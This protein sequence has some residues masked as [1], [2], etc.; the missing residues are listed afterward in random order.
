MG[1][2]TVLA[3][4]AGVTALAAG[5]GAVAQKSAADKAAAAQKKAL[6]EQNSAFGQ[7]NPD[8]VNK[9]AQEADAERAKGRVAL[10][11]ELDPELA[12]LRQL[13]KEG[14]VAVAA[15]D[16]I[17]KASDLLF[18]EN[19]VAD[20]RLEALKDQLINRAQEELNL[21][22]SLPAEFQNELVRA[23]VSRGAATG[24]AIDQRSIG[25][26][27]AQA[28]G[29]AGLALQRNR[30]QA[31][32]NLIGQAQAITD[33]RTNILANIFPKVETVRAATAAGQFATAEQALPEFGLSGE[34][35]ANLQIA[36]VQAQNA[37]TQ[38]K[39]DLS[40]QNAM[41]Q[42]QFT[43]Q[44]IGAGAGALTGA[45]GAASAGGAF[46][47]VPTSPGVANPYLGAAAGSV[48]YSYSGDPGSLVNQR[49][50][51]GV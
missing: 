44:L 10:Q 16:R 5:A 40:A 35:I 26:P 3:I 43:S 20:P 36:R 9:L 50:L 34:N 4:T 32:G 13:G 18:K 2:A 51:Y 11:K 8:R 46:S 17:R 33:A 22:A 39:A 42:G 7:L 23:G 1:V 6:K 19:A 15:D 27:V 49:F 30:E 24:L 41:A 29:S 21:G 12:Q 31:A 48:P 47:S 25:G 45:L 28:L 37:L 38:K 14:L